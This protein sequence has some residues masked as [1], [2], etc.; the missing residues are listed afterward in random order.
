MK[1]IAVIFVYAFMITQSQAQIKEFAFTESA[2]HSKL[3]KAHTFYH[4]DGTSVTIHFFHADQ[5]DSL[6]LIQNLTQKV[7]SEIQSVVQ[8]PDYA[9]IVKRVDYLYLSDSSK[10][11]VRAF[12]QYGDGYQYKD[13]KAS[14][15]KLGKDTLRIILQTQYRTDAKGNRHRQLYYLTFTVNDIKDI[16]GYNDQLLTDAINTA[17]QQSLVYGKHAYKSSFPVSYNWIDQRWVKYESEVKKSRKSF[18]EPDIYVGFQYV[19]SAWVPSAAVG[20]QWVK[21]SY[22]GERN[23]FKLLWEPHFLFVRNADDNLRIRRND[24]ITFRFVE[25][26]TK[27]VGKV[28]VPTS[29]SLGYLAGRKGDLFE[30]NTFK[31]SV[32]GFA[33]EGLRIEPEF[34][35]HDFFKQFSPSIRISLHLD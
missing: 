29:F 8:Q 20:I 4:N 18:I 3:I 1:K 28:H 14:A 16:A 19:R 9:N 15:T 27:G 25:Y 26:S 13:G 7:W 32:P 17:Q 11:R 10:F 24:F 34:F 30:K 6:L 22:I 35:F 23:V 2:I 31:F 12:P 5:L 21:G 33:Y